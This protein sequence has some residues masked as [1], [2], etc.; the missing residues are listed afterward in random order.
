M[1][2][3]GQ[4]QRLHLVRCDVAFATDRRQ[5][6]GPAQQRDTG[7]R[8]GPQG[9]AAMGTCGADQI[10]DVVQHAVFDVHAVDLGAQG[11]VLRCGVNGAQTGRGQVV[12][13]GCFSPQ[14]Q[15][16]FT[17]EIAEVLVYRRVVPPADDLRL[18]VYL[19]AKWGL[20]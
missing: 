1:A 10:H 11:G 5:G 9:K 12:R 18:R 20:R 16:F 2:Q 15:T 3:N 7:T 19:A 4:G 8:A 13:V 17:G 6:L 14:P